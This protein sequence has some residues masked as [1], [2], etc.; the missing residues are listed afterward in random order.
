MSPPK[1]QR[2]QAKLTEAVEI[3]RLRN[4]VG[5]A[6]FEHRLTQGA[7]E[8]RVEIQL[9][10]LNKPEFELFRDAQRALC[11]LE[12]HSSSKRESV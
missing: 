8:L 10:Q 12:A 5:R 1:R 2:L 6:V 7:G 4:E 3:L 9:I 11:R